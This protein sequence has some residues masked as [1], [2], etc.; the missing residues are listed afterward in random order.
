MGFRGFALPFS[1]EYRRILKYFAPQAS[2]GRV[3]E[4]VECGWEDETI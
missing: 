2:L 1:L 3:K 4:M